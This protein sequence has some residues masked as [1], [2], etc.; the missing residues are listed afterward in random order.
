[1]NITEMYENVTPV[2][3]TLGATLS[4]KRYFLAY[5]G[6]LWVPAKNERKKAVKFVGQKRP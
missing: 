3:D 6:L 4:L 2:E 1:M 5:F